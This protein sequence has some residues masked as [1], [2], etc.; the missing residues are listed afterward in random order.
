MEDVA[1]RPRQ[2]WTGRAAPRRRRRSGSSIGGT[3]G[4][5]KE[6]KTRRR[7]RWKRRWRSSRRL[8]SLADDAPNTTMVNEWFVDDRWRLFCNVCGP[9]RARVCKADLDSHALPRSLINSEVHW[10]PAWNI[11]GMCNGFCGNAADHVPHTK[12]QGAVGY[13]WAGLTIPEANAPV[14]MAA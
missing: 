4:G 13:A 11:K 12:K 7:T 8:P 10:C 9:M 14:A 3:R 5:V 6:D 2:E 1:L